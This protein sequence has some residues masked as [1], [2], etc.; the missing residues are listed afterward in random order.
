MLA[1]WLPAGAAQEGVNAAAPDRAALESQK[2]QI[3]QRL[4]QA[5]VA[6]YQ[7]FSVEDCLRTERRK[8]RLEGAGVREREAIMHTQERR[9][10]AD[11]RL[12]NTEERLRLKGHPDATGPARAALALPPPNPQRRSAVPAKP[13]AEQVRRQQA[14]HRAIAARTAQAAE[15]QNRQMRQIQKREAAQA[16]KI[17]V[18]RTQAEKNP[19]GRPPAAPLPVL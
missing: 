2:S 6:C 10:R 7:R 13:G 17:Q 4:Q 11:Q 14:H 1:L 15:A 19:P 8:A 12:Q 9:Q 16:H 3:N 18:Q 5:E